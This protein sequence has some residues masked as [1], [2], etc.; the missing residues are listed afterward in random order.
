ML[1]FVAIALA[2]GLFAQSLVLRKR[3]QRDAAKIRGLEADRDQLTAQV[4]ARE[5]ALAELQDA[6]RARGEALTELAERLQ[7][8]EALLALVTQQRED[9]QT[10]L[11]RT[12]GESQQFRAFFST[13]LHVAYDI[14]IVLHEDTTILAHNDAAVNLFGDR[15]VIGQKI[16]DVVDY[17]ELMQLVEHTLDADE[18]FEIQITIET[19]TFRARSCKR[20]YSDDAVFIGIALQNITDLVRL[21][22]ARRDMV[23]NISH[24]LRTPIANIRLIIDSLFHEQ[25]KPKRK[26]SIDSLRAI[27]NETDNVLWILQELLDLSMIESGQAIMRLVDSSLKDIAE[28]AVARLEDQLDQKRLKV[29]VDVPEDLYVLADA[30]QARRVFVN[31]LHNAIKWSPKGGNIQIQAFSLGEEVEVNVKDEGPGVPDAQSE[32][33]FERFYQ[34]DASRSGHEGTG[35]GLAI[36]RHIVNAHGGRIWAMGNGATDGGEFSFTLLPG[37]PPKA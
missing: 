8:Q 31:L 23:A 34:V 24:E 36:C 19:R 18:E 16:G 30:D 21:N 32:R 26:E 7:D 29:Q 14:V 5:V 3:Q 35:L 37:S 25:D 13:L 27:A 15:H 17:A 1:V 9:L 33:I 12:S 2:A 10:A 20:Q 6:D 4:R 28:T 11:A 22:R